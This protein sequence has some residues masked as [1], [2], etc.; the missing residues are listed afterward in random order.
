MFSTNLSTAGSLPSFFE[1]YAQGTLIDG[2]R[3]AFSYGLTRLIESFETM[4]APSSSLG[5]VVPFQFLGSSVASWSSEIFYAILFLLENHYLR[6]YDASFSENFYGLKRVSVKLGRDYVPKLVD[7]LQTSPVLQKALEQ[8]VKEAKELGETPLRDSDRRIALIFLIFVPY[9]KGVLDDWYVA[10][11]DPAAAHV[12]DEVQAQLH[13]W[14]QRARVWFK[15][16][17]P[18]FHASF[19]GCILFYQ[20]AYLFQRSYFYSPFLHVSGQKIRRLTQYDM[21]IG[22]EPSK[23]PANYLMRLL[24]YCAEYAKWGILLSIFGFRFYDWWRSQTFSDQVVSVPAPEVLESTARLTL[25]DDKSKCPLCRKV[26]VNPAAPLASGIV[27]CYA[28]IVQYV[29]EY[30]QCPATGFPCTED[31]IRKI[32][33]D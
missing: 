11:N 18:Y 24:Y 28:C 19:D 8:A 10:L 9:M 22:Q 21:L 31:Q 3:P 17:Y 6:E 23:V 30:H 32:Y 16:L 26:R 25:P 14:I 1:L 5:V 7:K 29:R 15:L 33:I 27:C 12:H 4:H 20:L 13:P 2:L